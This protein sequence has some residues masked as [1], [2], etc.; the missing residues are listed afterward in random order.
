M[1]LFLSKL[2]AVDNS[3]SFFRKTILV[4]K[5]RTFLQILFWLWL[6]W[7]LPWNYV[8]T[9]YNYTLYSPFNIRRSN[10]IGWCD[11]TS[12]FSRV[13]WFNFIFKFRGFFLCGVVSCCRGSVVRDR[14]HRSWGLI[15]RGQRGAGGLRGRSSRSTVGGGQSF[16][17]GGR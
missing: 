2:V 14:G 4:P 7:M 8:F 12:L 3:K 15:G 5:I 1:T 6:Y 9:L 16:R 10:L 17:E 11:I 13:S